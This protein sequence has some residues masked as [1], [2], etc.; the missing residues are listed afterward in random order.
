MAPINSE[1][2]TDA[3][4]ATDVDVHTIHNG[5][6]LFIS[7]GRCAMSGMIASSAEVTMW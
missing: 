5:H 1:A 7:G 4:T 3:N 2:G 6:L